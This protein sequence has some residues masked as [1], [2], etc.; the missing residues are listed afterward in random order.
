[1]T[2]RPKVRKGILTLM[3]S[4]GAGHCK[5]R[6]L[7]IRVPSDAITATGR[8]KKGILNYR[9]IKDLIEKEEEKLDEIFIGLRNELGRTPLLVEILDKYD[10]QGTEDEV[11]YTSPFIM[12]HW[13]EY[14]KYRE[15]Q[16]KGKQGSLQK[17]EDTEHDLVVM[18]RKRRLRLDEV[19][20]NMTSRFVAMLQ[21]GEGWSKKVNGNNTINKKLIEFKGFLYELGRKGLHNDTTYDKVVVSGYEAQEPSYTQAEL[22]A[23]Y[24]LDLSAVRFRDGHAIARDLYILCSETAVSF[25]DMKHFQ[26]ANLSEMEVDG[27]MIKFL[28]FRRKKTKKESIVPLSSRAQAIL[29]K[30]DWTAPAL[31]GTLCNQYIKDIAREAGI[32]GTHTFV[33]WVGNE[34]IETEV[35]RWE[36]I[37]FHSSRASFITNKLMEGDPIALIGL[38]AGQSQP[39]TTARYLRPG[40]GE[41]MEAFLRTR[42]KLF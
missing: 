33:K 17:V 6:S 42:K 10:Y 3:I 36:A 5:P 21:A 11:E 35:P 27:K 25:G 30:Y 41:Q 18:D 4:Q 22:D 19:G 8:L 32:T 29:G 23:I 40:A 38:M 13:A 39:S 1:M 16:L 31:S 12:D 28:K 37:K 7:G 20:I 34:C 9:E 24:E 26:S 14:F 2:V 15:I